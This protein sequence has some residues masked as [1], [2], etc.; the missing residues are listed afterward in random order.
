VVFLAVLMMLG[1]ET[2]LWSILDGFVSWVGGW[3]GSK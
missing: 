2:F 1:V 3:M